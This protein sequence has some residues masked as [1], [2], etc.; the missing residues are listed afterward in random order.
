MPFR[1]AEVSGWAAVLVQDERAEAGGPDQ[2][3]GT[4]TIVAQSLTHG[5][6]L[7]PRWRIVH[8]KMVWVTAALA[9]ALAAL[10]VVWLGLLWRLFVLR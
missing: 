7:P 9:L 6:R 1:P 3:T 5:A 10:S 2:P 8:I 4:I